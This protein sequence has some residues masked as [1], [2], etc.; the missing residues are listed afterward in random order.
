MLMKL[1]NYG[2]QGTAIDCFASYLKNRKQYV[3]YNGNSSKIMDVLCGAPQGSILGQLLYILYIN[4]HPNSM[5]LLKVIMFAEDASAYA[6]ML[7][8]SDVNND[9]KMTGSRLTNSP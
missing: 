5:K 3:H 8:L 6:H 7:V 2:F 9:L 4:Y 1:Q